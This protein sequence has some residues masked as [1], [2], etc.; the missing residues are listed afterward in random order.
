MIPTL[1]VLFCM[2]AN[3]KDSKSDVRIPTIHG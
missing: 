2:R 3:S 1:A